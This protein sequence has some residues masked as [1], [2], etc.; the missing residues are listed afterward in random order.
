MGVSGLL[1]NTNLILYDR[2]DG[3]TLY[4]QIAFKAVNGPRKGDTL[5]LLP[6]IET[7]WKTWQ[8]L[9]PRIRVIERGLYGIEAYT[10]YPYGEYRT[11]HQYLIFDL[12]I[13]LS[14][15]AIRRLTPSARWATGRSSTIRSAV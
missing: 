2:R 1:F 4:P 10:S 9:Y 8:E 3:T 6:V 7:T 11:D 13:P 14:Q 15:I 5:E 12:V